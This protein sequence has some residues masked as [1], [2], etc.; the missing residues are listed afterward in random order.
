MAEEGWTNN[1]VA[2]LAVKE[3]LKDI[4]NIDALILGCTH[5]PLFEDVIKKELGDT[6]EIIN[7][8]KMIAEKLKN[9][10]GKE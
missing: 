1:E 3:Y 10:I 9:N 5:Y 2:S 7:T 8:G 4:N 6:V